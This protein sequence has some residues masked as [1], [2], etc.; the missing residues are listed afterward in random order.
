MTTK[1]LP[2]PDDNVPV[3]TGRWY[4]VG[5]INVNCKTA[6]QIPW[7]SGTQVVIIYDEVDNELRIKPLVY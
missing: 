7:A 5:R 1:D 6:K 2:K 3:S 4:G